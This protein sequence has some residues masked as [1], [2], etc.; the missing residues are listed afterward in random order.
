M[1]TSPLFSKHLVISALTF[2]WTSSAS[3]YA[4]SCVDLF[5]RDWD[6][7]TGPTE[8][9]LSLVP[10]EPRAVRPPRDVFFETILDENLPVRRLGREDV[11]PEILRANLERTLPLLSTARLEKALES[12]L[13]D[14]IL[15]SSRGE[16]S[17]IALELTA[18]AYL[19]RNDRNGADVF[20]R[21]VV[22]IE[23]TESSLISLAM[24]A[25]Q[26]GLAL[27]MIK[28]G[29][30]VNGLVQGY[31][32]KRAGYS[33]LLGDRPL[34]SWNWDSPTVYSNLLLSGLLGYTDV[35]KELLARGAQILYL[36][37]LVVSDSRL[38]RT[39]YFSELRI[40]L[41][42]GKFEAAGLM[43]PYFPGSHAAIT[44]KDSSADEQPRRLAQ[45][46][47]PYGDRSYS[48][49]APA[50]SYA[51]ANDHS[52]PGETPLTL[53]RIYQDEPDAQP[54]L[55]AIRSSLLPL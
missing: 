32:L 24:M 40:L 16:A 37:S 42:A 52:E 26:P 27:R 14:R 45:A 44:V 29:V 43:F 38:H 6:K 25:Y 46:P 22:S 3:A 55:N 23:P 11:D 20:D 9:E 7:I 47:Y 31:L 53:I 13:M 18:D 41:D 8:V 21:F 4:T 2:I 51:Q 36:R 49:S 30:P 10:I 54:F 39:D 12:I 19:S 50:L 17:Q 34:D 48:T 28:A 1:P 5:R 35:T 33:Q 15:T